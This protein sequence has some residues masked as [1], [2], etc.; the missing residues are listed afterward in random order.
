MVSSGYEAV[1]LADGNQQDAAQTSFAALATRVGEREASGGAW[2]TQLK[3]DIE[4]RASK[5]LVGKDRYNRWG[6][7]YLR[8]FTR[9]HQV[10]YCTNYMDKSLQEY[11]GALFR[12]LREEGDGVFV[13]LPPPKPSAKKTQTVA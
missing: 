5:A 2:V 7:H 10:Q 12:A 4:G 1:R 13:S 6:K 8:A 9:A 11:G 3:A